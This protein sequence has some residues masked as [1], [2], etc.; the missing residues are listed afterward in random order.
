MSFPRL[1]LAALVLF[2]LQPFARAFD[3][4]FISEF[5]ASNDT[6]LTDED[7]DHSDWI[8]IY[9]SGATTVNLGG[10]RLTDESGVLD[11]WVFPSVDL[12]PK[13]FLLVFASNKDRAAAGAPL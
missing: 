4:V 11:K 10:W 12:A 1:L 3:P 5:L 7:G 2:A 8:E 9:N 6:G 13:G